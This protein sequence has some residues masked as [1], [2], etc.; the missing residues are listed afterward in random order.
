VGALLVLAAFT[1]SL[2]GTNLVGSV[3]SELRVALDRATPLVAAGTVRVPQSVDE[4]V[5]VLDTGGNPLD[6]RPRPGLSGPDVKAL[7]SGVD[8]FRDG[9][10]PP[11][12]WLGRVVTA[13][14]GG[15]RLLVA[16]TGLVG[17][18]E[19][20]QT[21]QRWVLIGAVLGGIAV[22]AATWLAVRASLRPVQRMRGAARALPPGER[23]PVPVA[24]DELRELAEALNG[25]LARRDAARE[26]LQR[27]TGDAAHELRSPVA[28]IRA[29]AEVGA[30]YPDP[31]TSAEVLADVAAEAERMS[32]LVGDL[33]VL[34]R[35]DAGELPEVASVDLAFSAQ[36]AIERL[37]SD[38]G[39]GVRLEVPARH[40]AVLASP[41]EVDLVLDN[42]LRNAVRHAAAQ[43]TVLVL[44]AGDRV[45]LV[46][47]DDGPGI[48]AEHR[49]KVFDRFY[50]VSDDR[51][52]DSGG[53]GLGLALV[54]ELVRRRKGG[55]AVGESPEGGARFDVR[56]PAV[57]NSGA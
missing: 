1:P 9:D 41:A 31:E 30:L 26:R 40:V 22:G 43:V 3:D 23:L 51:A 47:D 24:T 36:A 16:G 49:A 44:P 19:A 45:R 27:F 50:R 57:G 15:Q 12:R 42:L 7:K 13:P 25:L 55:V 14:D 8:V 54:A 11:H 32:K 46:V 38:G 6:G 28:S 37:A 17:Y 52:R 20:Q 10:D 21:G 34:A 35:S 4:R 29:Q 5:R 39:P 53:S 33:L 56:W 48:P 18:F 2:V